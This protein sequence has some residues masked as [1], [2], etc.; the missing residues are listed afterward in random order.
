MDRWSDR[1]WGEAFSLSYS[2]QASRRRVSRLLAE[3][4][5]AW[6][7]LG[8]RRRRA[9]IGT[10]GLIE[11]AIDTAGICNQRLCKFVHTKR[12]RH[13]NPRRRELDPN[14]H[15]QDRKKSIFKRRLCS[16]RRQRTYASSRLNRLTT[17]PRQRI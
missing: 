13:R 2:S 10:I 17:R 8:R 1:R 14:N 11:R 9:C 7:A 5:S 16:Q 6:P 3:R 12:R 15:R 4:L